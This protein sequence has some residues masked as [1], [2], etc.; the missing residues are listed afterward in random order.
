MV[1]NTLVKKEAYPNPT[2]SYIAQF[3]DAFIVLGLCTSIVQH[4]AIL[5]R[6]SKTQFVPHFHYANPSRISSCI[7]HDNG[8]C[9]NWVHS[10]CRKSIL[11][12]FD[13]DLS[14]DHAQ[15]TWQ[16]SAEIMHSKTDKALIIWL[17]SFVGKEVR[18]SQMQDAMSGDHY[19]Q[20]WNQD[21]TISWQ[22][23]ETTIAKVNPNCH[24]IEKLECSF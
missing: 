5:L 4:R 17:P 14:W 23:Q 13:P 18:I 12:N 24:P 3:H 11:S 2:D 7:L 1:L 19:G 9:K 8:S 20:Y 10:W 6:S 22:W 21:I 15:Q 16:S